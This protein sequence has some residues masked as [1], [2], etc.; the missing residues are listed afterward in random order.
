MMHGAHQDADRRSAGTIAKLLFAAGAALAILVLGACGSDLGSDDEG[1]EAEVQVAD[2]EPVEGEPLTISSAVLYIDKAGGA[3]DGPGSTLSNFTEETGIEVEYLEE[4]NSNESHFAKLRPELENGSSGGR[5]MI[6]A[7]DWM[8]RK[9]YDLGYLQELD[10]SAL[11]NV[12][13]NLLPELQN[14]EFD[15]ERNFTVPYQ[16]GMTGLIVRSDLAPDITSINDI[17]DPQYKGKV[18]MLS[19]LRDTVP[20][21][22]MAD[23]IDPSEATKEDWLAAIDKIEAAVDSGQIRDITGNDY[24]DDVPRGDLVAAVGWSGDAVQMQLDNPAIEF[25]V[26]DEGCILWSD[27]WIIPVG[28]PNPG[29]AYEFLNFIYEPENA[30]QIAAYVN[31]TTPVDGVQ[32]VFEE[33]N[34]D[35]ATNDLIFPSDGFTEG[36]ESQPILEG[37]DAEEIEEAWEQVTTG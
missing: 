20:L 8:A 19:E 6:V 10:K 1:D 37:A 21:V 4:I 29:A 31:Y 34:S 36:C 11:P 35:L 17:F 9:Y 15:P 27:D 2:T 3:V 5:D 32:E 23:G 13:A 7:T 33:Q 18:A 22:M 12:E 28:A 14:P 25:R 26:P 16:S 30:A 24:V